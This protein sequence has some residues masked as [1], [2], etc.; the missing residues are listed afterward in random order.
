M[1][2]DVY[3]GPEGKVTIVPIDHA[4]LVIRYGNEAI[5]VD[6]VG[7]AALYAGEPPPT[8][9]LITHEHGDHFDLPTLEAL[10]AG[11]AVPMIVN[12]VVY[13][14]LPPSFERNAT[15]LRNGQLG[16]ILGLKIGAVPAYNTSPGKEKYHPQGVG[17]G[18]VFAPNELR[19]YIPS[20]GEDTPEMKALQGID[21][22]FLPMNQPYTMTPEQ[23]AGAIGAFKPHFAYPFHYR[24]TDPQVLK[25]LVPKD[26]GTEVV[27]RDWYARR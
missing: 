5:Y 17:N 13:K 10:T 12:G 1:S 25:S 4:S 11:R 3:D 16:E 20:D 24:G 18:Y 14:T 7:G 6:P 15:M 26:S 27:I 23:A 9:I 19:I 21:I 2:D 22:A 8:A